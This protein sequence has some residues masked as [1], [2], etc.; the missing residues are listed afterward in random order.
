LIWQ[1]PEGSLAKHPC[2][3]GTLDLRPSDQD[4]VA[5]IRKGLDLIMAIDSGS[6][7]TGGWGRGRRRGLPETNARGGVSPGKRVSGAT[8]LRLG[9]GLA[10]EIAGRMRNSLGWI[11]GCCGGVRQAHGV[12]AARCD[13][14]PPAGV[15]LCCV[16]GLRPTKS[17]AKEGEGRGVAHR[18]CRPGRSSSAATPA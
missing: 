7:A 18:G 3:N 9:R 13:G 5:Q 17:S 14:K 8:E 6:A 4:R 11:S 10:G 2:R 15:P 16:G 1:K 12:E